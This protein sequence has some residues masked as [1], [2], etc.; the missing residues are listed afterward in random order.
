MTAWAVLFAAA[1]AT[2]LLRISMV[3][4]LAGRSVPARV[5]R[6]LSVMGPAVLAAIVANSLFVHHGAPALP[7][8]PTALGVAAAVLVVA[9]T[10]RPNRALLV[11]LPVAW[12]ATLLLPT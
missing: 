2:Y 7:T 4:A 9:R 12:L 6:R 10:R 5:E 1:A 3:V 8:V 11:G